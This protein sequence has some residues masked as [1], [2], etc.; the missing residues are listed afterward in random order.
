MFI[1]ICNNI[2]L[3]LFTIIN[4]GCICS[5]VC[6]K[7]NSCFLFGSSYFGDDFELMEMILVCFSI[8][9]VVFN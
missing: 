4:G 5:W 3:P 8:H 1:S 7:K 6:K 9:L 2:A